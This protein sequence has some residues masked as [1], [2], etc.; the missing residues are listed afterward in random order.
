MDLKRLKYFI[1]IARHKSINGASK[2]LL[3][4]QPSLSRQLKILE[5]EIGYRLCERTRNGVALTKKGEFFFNRIVPHVEALEDTIAQVRSRSLVQ[6]VELRIA[7]CPTLVD[8][9]SGPF[10]LAV[11]R[12]LPNASLKLTELYAGVSR[13]LLHD[14]ELDGATLYGPK[15]NLMNLEWG[16]LLSKS[17]MEVLF[18]EDFVLVGPSDSPFP[19]DYVPTADDIIGLKLA[20]NH[21]DGQ[22]PQMR[23]AME[24]LQMKSG[25][26]LH[27]T[28]SESARILK[29]LALHGGCYAFLPRSSIIDAEQAGTA[30]VWP[31][32]DPGIER[33]VVFAV[34]DQSRN[35]DLMVT[36]GEIMK[37]T[38][39]AA[40][41]ETG[42]RVAH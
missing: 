28:E 29:N 7:I 3:I 25:G 42:W 16:H 19:E 36:I 33:H 11:A 17:T 6:G 4:S 18:V 5:E 39:V 22:F 20:V 10:E 27:T 32:V 12:E 1:A 14:G 9:I 23:E 31:L 21:R 38:I 2:S 30:R 40:A 37:R 15:S 24:Y 35:K 8:R 26:H 34:S 41:G 13:Q